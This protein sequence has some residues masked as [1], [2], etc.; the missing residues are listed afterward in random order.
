MNYFH[1]SLYLS[2]SVYFF[3]S[4]SLYLRVPPF[5]YL[6]ISLSLSYSISPFHYIINISPYLLLS[7][8]FFLLFPLFCMQVQK[9]LEKHFKGNLCS[10]S[11]KKEQRRKG[12]RLTLLRMG[13]FYP[14]LWWGGRGWMCPPFLI[15]ENNRKSKEQ[16][17]KKF[18]T[19]FWLYK[20][21]SNMKQNASW[22]FPRFS[23]KNDKYPFFYVNPV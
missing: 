20:N 16:G 18:L 22:H 4:L 19:N 15:S 21:K 6:T 1:I 8:F 12:D 14:H 9:E 2:F 23:L 13:C 11:E 5:L 10:V 17:R 3:L 7:F